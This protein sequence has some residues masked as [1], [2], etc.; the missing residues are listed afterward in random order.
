MRSQKKLLKQEFK[1]YKQR[2]K[3][4][5]SLSGNLVD[6]MN[7]ATEEE[8]KAFADNIF[9]N[10]YEAYVNIMNGFSTGLEILALVIAV[11]AQK[12]RES[13]TTYNP[14][15]ILSQNSENF[16]DYLATKAIDGETKR[17]DTICQLSSISRH[18]TACSFFISPR[19]VECIYLDPSRSEYNT[20]ELYKL[21][22]PFKLAGVKFLSHGYQ[23]THQTPTLQQGIYGCGIYAESLLRKMHRMDLDTLK[24]NIPDSSKFK[25]LHPCFMKYTQSISVLD[26]YFETNT[27]AKFGLSKEYTYEEL[28]ARYFKNALRARA[29]FSIEYATQ[30]RAL[31]IT[32]LQS[33]QRAKTFIDTHTLQDVLKLLNDCIYDISKN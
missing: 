15:L 8:Q 10:D 6:M 16:F 7:L 22:T 17:L 5:I 26:S 11:R 29:N 2:L 13:H 23:P 33:L 3:R 27:D 21:T 4:Q 9:E 25:K 31:D 19:K 28:E 14:L 12:L 18:V 32:R 20:L 1:K 30:N 24:K